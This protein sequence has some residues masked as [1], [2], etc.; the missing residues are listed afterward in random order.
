VSVLCEF[1]ASPPMDLSGQS[2]F[3]GLVRTR[4]R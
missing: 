3:L 4:H 2:I 1:V